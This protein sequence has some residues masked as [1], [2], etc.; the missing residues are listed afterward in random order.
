MHSDNKSPRIPAVSPE[1]K[2]SAAALSSICF[3]AS[4]ICWS[5]SIP[6]PPALGLSLMHS[7][8]NQALTP[9]T[10]NGARNDIASTRHILLLI[11]VSL[12]RERSLQKSFLYSEKLVDSILPV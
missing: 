3:S 1:L 9:L 4:A 10:M 6:P 5:V 2:N 12:V 8:H 11:S 7:V